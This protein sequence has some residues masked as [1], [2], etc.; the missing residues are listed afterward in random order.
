MPFQ[1]TSVRTDL[2]K[3]MH[4]IPQLLIPSL[5][6]SKYFSVI[7]YDRTLDTL[8]ELGIDP[9]KPYAADDLGR[10][11]RRTGATHAVT[12]I[13][14][15][16]G[17]GLCIALTTSRIGADE[18]FSSR[19]D[20]ADGAA[21]IEAS[22][23]ISDQVKRDLGLTRTTQSDDFDAIGV[24]VT[25]ASLEAFRLYNEGRRLHVAGTYAESARVMRRALDLDPE[26]ALA[27]R[28]LAVS[29][30]SQGED[31]AATGCFL[32]A[33]EA[34]RNATTQERFFIRS[35]YFQHRM[36]FGRAL[37]VAREW[38]SL[39]PDDTQALLFA[40][41]AGLF[42]EEAED[43]H[44]ALVE[45]LRKGDRNPFLFFFTSLS[46]T[47]M[48]RFDEAAEVR[49]R[50]LSI[51]PE[52]RIIT[53]AAVIDALVRGQYDRALGELGG[54]KGMEPDVSFDL[55]SGDIHLL[56][57]DFRNAE[58]RYQDALTRSSRAATRLSLLAL[59]EGRY[60]RAAALAADAGNDE[61]L[62]YIAS[63]RGQLPA[64]LEAAAK[65]V[66]AAEEQGHRL[67]LLVALVLRGAIEAR[68]GDLVAARADA[69]RI[70]ASGGSGLAKAHERAVRFL[71]G[72]IASAEGRGTEAAEEFEAMTGLLPRDVPYLD[73]YP[74]SLGV[75]ASLQ[76]LF[77]HTAA[78]ENEKADRP[79]AAL[80]LY[81]RL[82]ALNGGRLQHP[83][84]FA[85]SHYA[86]GR[87]K[88]SRGD[89]E[90]AG[91]SLT[92]F[93]SLWKD[94]DPGLPEVED[95]KRRLAALLR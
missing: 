25:A 67:E 88:Q 45:G 3:W 89:L 81:L 84:F 33:L 35:S 41:L 1:N 26:F 24:P 15:E 9:A 54:T 49:E 13:L 17:D 7:G 83:D 63:R 43:A 39:Y 82:L 2:D 46:C 40:G 19:F 47:A 56:K 69:E 21:I 6:G 50:G 14:I 51:H 5:S 38:A 80:E 31:Q 78:V 30:A 10:I 77:L 86:V 53:T 95:A 91:E 61:L 93:L 34:S 29:L 32:K 73:D 94:A 92:M 90:G 44:S 74:R 11:K 60:T 16:A 12:G 85:L 23:R 75:L 62:A 68:S 4:G 8:R 66:K 87:I 58:K 27:W 42:E 36:E 79:E 57:G 70:R 76:A 18:A 55:I 72:M 22:G 71:R 59:A 37:Q 52:N 48:G 28:S 64:G 20:C 65:A